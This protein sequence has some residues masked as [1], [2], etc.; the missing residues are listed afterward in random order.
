MSFLTVYYSERGGIMNRRIWVIILFLVGAGLWSGCASTVYL[1]A[2]PPADPFAGGGEP[3]YVTN[4]ELKREY[5]ILRSSKIYTLTNQV[6]GARKLTLRPLHQMGQCGTPLVLSGLT[7]GILPGFL[8][9]GYWFRYELEKDG[10]TEQWGHPLPVYERYSIWEWLVKL[11][12][13]DNKV[14]AQ[15]L[16]NS[17]RKHWVKNWD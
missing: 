3:V 17:R 16:A 4:P 11:K 13:D 10:V 9:G 12:H 5:A 8:E 1:M 2:K 14:F 6:E 15:G 7:L